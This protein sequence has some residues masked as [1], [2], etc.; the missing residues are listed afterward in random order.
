MAKYKRVFQMGFD[1][2]EGQDVPEGEIE[3]LFDALQHHIDNFYDGFGRRIE[4]KSV[5][6]FNVE[7][8]SHAYGEIELKQINQE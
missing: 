2:A 5:G 7:D 8:M 3:S 4:F 6:E 1:I